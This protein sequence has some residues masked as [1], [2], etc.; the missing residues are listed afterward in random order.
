MRITL[1]VIFGAIGA[2]ILLWQGPLAAQKSSDATKSALQNSIFC[3]EKPDPK[4]PER[5]L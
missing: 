1:A 3:T 2:L 5:D 4:R